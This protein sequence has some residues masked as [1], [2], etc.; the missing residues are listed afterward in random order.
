MV[1]VAIAGASG[2]IG[3]LL[4]EDLSND[5]EVMALGRNPSKTQFNEGST[6]FV[7]RGC[8]LFS[9]IQTEAALEGAEIALYL[10][11]SMLPRASL[12]Q[13]SFEDCDLL[14][15]DNFARAARKCGVKRIIYLGGLIPKGNTLSAHL[16]SRLEVER[17]LASTG[18]PVTTLR[19]GLILGAR[20]S[21]FQMLYLLVKYLPVMICPSWT[22]TLTQCIFYRDVVNLIRFCIENDQTMAR[23]YDIGIPEVITYRQ[24]MSLLAEEMHVRRFFFSVS[25]FTPGL[26]RLWVQLI[27]GASRNLVAPLIQSL[28]HEMIVQNDE[29]LRLYGKPLVTMRQALWESIQAISPN[30]RAQTKGRIRQ[31]R[32]DP[33]VRSIQR[34]AVPEGKNAQSIANAYF[35]W[36]PKFLRPLVVVEEQAHRP[37]VWAFRFSFL[38]VPL[39]MLEH[40]PKR[41]SEDRQLFYICGGLL[42]ARDQNPNARLEFREVMAGTFCL[43]AIHEFK[44]ALPWP[45]YKYTQA[46]LHLWVMNSFRAFLARS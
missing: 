39:L 2:F 32:F 21:S 45:I 35:D 24:L 28:E 34:L 14:L 19:A 15:A 10:V 17:A 40:C 7:W 5:F 30:L 3:Q 13:S 27:T 12:T 29:L 41:S 8:D 23:T 31:L 26:S 16:K 22:Q 42:S 4:L 20:G 37:G 18:I 33:E 43:A 25:F 1:K 44:P 6:N 36:L 46:I 11:H 38:K 9:L